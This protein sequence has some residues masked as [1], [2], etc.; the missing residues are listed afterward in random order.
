M[1]CEFSGVVTDDAREIVDFQGYRVTRDGR[2]Q[3]QWRRGTT[4]FS[5]E[6]RDLSFSKDS[7]GYPGLTICNRTR[8]W[9]VRIHR[10]I[11]A[12]FVPNPDNLPCVRH[13]DGSRDHNAAS[14]LAW[15]TYTDNENDKKAHGT[16][17]IGRESAGKLTKEQRGAAARWAADGLSQKEIAKRLNVSR[18]TVT[19]LLNKTTWNR[20]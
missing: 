20:R 15:G 3:S 9:K 10:L 7:K 17:E 16:W 11:A 14:N 12:A 8:R 5:K 18:P 1:A 4:V 13:L 2:I 6:W 19:R